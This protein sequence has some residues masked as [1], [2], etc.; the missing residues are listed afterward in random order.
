MGLRRSDRLALQYFLV[1]KDFH[2]S[3][4]LVAAYGPAFLQG[5][6]PQ[7]PAPVDAPMTSPDT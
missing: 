2:Q 4:Y 1:A 6:F 7:L 5:S 3:F